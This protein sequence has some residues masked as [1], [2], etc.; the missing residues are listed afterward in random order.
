M[1]VQSGSKGRSATWVFHI[2]LVFFMCFFCFMS[3]PQGIFTC[4][5]LLHPDL[6]LDA[7]VLGKPF[8]PLVIFLHS[9]HS[10]AQ[11]SGF[12]LIVDNYDCGICL[13]QYFLALLLAEFISFTLLSCYLFLNDLKSKLRRK[14]TEIKKIDFKKCSRI[15]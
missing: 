1:C 13:F 15:N 4:S 14:K 5:Q 12:S 9:I 11:V 6:S 2:A 3:K 10:C 8:L 7:E